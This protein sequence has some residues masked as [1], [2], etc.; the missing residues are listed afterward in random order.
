MNGGPAATARPGPKQPHTH[1]FHDPAVHLH[2]LPLHGERPRARPA[3]TTSQMQRETDEVPANPQAPH[4]AS[5]PGSPE[6]ER[7]RASRETVAVGANS[8]GDRVRSST[9][10]PHPALKEATR[11][12]VGLYSIQTSRE[13]GRPQGGDTAK[14]SGSRSSFPNRYSL[15]LS[16]P[17][18][19]SS[20]LSSILRYLKDGGV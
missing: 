18:M 7:T 12:V 20:A 4:C 6:G 5:G 19:C 16:F 13:L 9:H 14:P 15:Q 3:A 17:V 10:A 2:P 8:S 1:S 11:G